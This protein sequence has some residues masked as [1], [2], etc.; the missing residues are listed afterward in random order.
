MNIYINRAIQILLIATIVLSS[1][2]SNGKQVDHHVHEEEH[3]DEGVIELTD[4]QVKQAGIEIGTFSYHTLGSNIEAN[5]AI[6]LPPNNL[7]S[8]NVSMEGFVEDIRFLEGAEVKKGQTL[9]VLKHPS[10][11]QLQQDYLQAISQLT[12]LEQ[13][14]VRQKTLAEAKVSAEKTFQK[15]QS[16]YN[17]TRAKVSALTEKLRFLGISP[18]H[19]AKGN[20]QS[21]VYLPA[22]FNGTITQLN[23]HRGQLVTPNDVIM[24]V[25]DREHMHVEL[26]VFQSDIPKVKKGQK[27][28]FTIPA[29]ENGSVYE[30]RISLVGKNLDLDTKTIRVHG[31]FEEQEILIPGLY[32]EAQIVTEPQMR[33][34]LP[35]DAIIRDEGHY[36]YFIQSGKEGEHILF[37]KVKIQEG[38]T[39][40]GLTEVAAFSSDSDTTNIVTKGAFYLKS[41][42]NKEKGGHGH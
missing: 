11:I 1:C 38:I 41:E 8:I 6:E 28:L 20:I 19:V 31:H 32:V 29:F 17:G 35:E 30:G 21:M 26:Q 25:I 10:Y 14:L 18:G 34:V 23:V 15:I 22:P 4:I 37:E 39:E 13:E 24:E 27:I 3:H 7:A 5:G 2:G 33:R 9:V 16:D 42:M 36:Y 40:L 12:F